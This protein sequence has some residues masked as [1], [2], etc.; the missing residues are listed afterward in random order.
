MQN[1]LVNSLR[2][3]FFFFRMSVS[4]CYYGL[5]FKA[6]EMASNIYL[7]AFLASLT[8]IPSYVIGCVIIRYLSRKMNIIGS[9]IIGGVA[10]L[11]ILAVPVRKYKFFRNCM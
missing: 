9:F 11:A 7:G 1:G 10:C 4:L 3:Y 2:I 8:E 6:P 5:S